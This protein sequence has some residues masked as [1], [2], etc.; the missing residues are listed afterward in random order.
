M[1]ISVEFSDKMY[2]FKNDSKL[3][4]L[5]VIEED[6]LFEVKLSELKESDLD[7]HL[8]LYKNVENI[9]KAA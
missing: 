6:M 5:R 7:M 4:S 3:D 2:I 9:S 1:K 8:V